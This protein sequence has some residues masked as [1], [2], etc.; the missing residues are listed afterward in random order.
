MLTA[1]CVTTLVTQ[2]RT[3]VRFPR[4]AS[5]S[6]FQSSNRSPQSTQQ[7]NFRLRYVW[8]QAISMSTTLTRTISTRF[9]LKLPS[10]L[11]QVDA[12]QYHLDFVTSTDRLSDGTKKF[13][14]PTS[15][16]RTKF[17]FKLD[18]WNCLTTTCK[19]RTWWQRIRVSTLLTGPQSPAERF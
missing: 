10:Q 3:P 19:Q 17:Q 7:L 5:S 4:F 18:H 6:P 8:K 16:D 1:R 13:S 14:W 9:K 2:Y 15:P 12:N 11:L